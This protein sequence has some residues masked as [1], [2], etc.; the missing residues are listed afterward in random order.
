MLVRETHNGYLASLECK[1]I[2]RQARAEQEEMFRKLED[3]LHKKLQGFQVQQAALCQV[4][5]RFITSLKAIMPQELEE[6]SP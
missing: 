6:V 3:K 2:Q 4:V 1:K 5:A